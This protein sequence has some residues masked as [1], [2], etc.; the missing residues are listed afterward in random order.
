MQ[1]NYNG[2]KSASAIRIVSKLHEGMEGTKREFA[3]ACFCSERSLDTAFKVLRDC[4]LMHIS[5]WKRRLGK[6]AQLTA[7]YSYGPGP[8]AQRPKKGRAD[9]VHIDASL[10]GKE[11]LAVINEHG[12]EKVGVIHSRLTYSYEYLCKLLREMTRQKRVHIDR[13]ERQIQGGAYSP[14]YAAGEGLNARKPKAIKP[15]EASS[16][17]KAKLIDEYGEEIASK[18]MRS[19]KQGGADKIVVDG[20]LIYERGP[21]RV[22]CCAV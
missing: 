11:V 22:R 17:R 3:D 12:P 16:N 9:Y 19:R 6:G 13:Y 15:R 2:T 14:V 8:D 7:Y 4:G 10:A 18:I 20:R 21:S 1:Y 5:S